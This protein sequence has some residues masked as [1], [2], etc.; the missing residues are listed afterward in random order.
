[1]LPCTFLAVSLACVCGVYSADAEIRVGRTTVSVATPT[2][3]RV[4]HSPTDVIPVKHSLVVKPDWPKVPYQ[5]TE[6]KTT[7]TIT[8][9]ALAVQ[10]D[11]NSGKVT[12]LD[13]SEHN[14][15]LAEDTT[16]FSPGANQVLRNRTVP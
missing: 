9:T 7:K 3:V 2:I 11:K 6:T 5:V 15:L 10:V 1:M 8:T 4:T 13:A 12:M 14:V 16:S